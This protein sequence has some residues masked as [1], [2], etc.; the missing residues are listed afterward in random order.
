M[1]DVLPDPGP[2]KIALL[3]QALWLTRYLLSI[4][5]SLKSN[6]G[7]DFLQRA[8]IKAKR[9]LPFF[10]LDPQKTFPYTLKVVRGFSV[11]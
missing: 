3:A 2:V 6:E 9:S 4:I 1:I 5:K 7:N 8:L 11:S 10:P